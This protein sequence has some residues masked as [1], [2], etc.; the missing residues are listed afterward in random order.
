MQI[1]VL[2][3]NGGKRVT[4]DDS[5]LGWLLAGAILLATSCVWLGFAWGTAKSPIVHAD[6]DYRYAIALMTQQHELNRAV[7]ETV[8]ELEILRARTAAL[9]A[10][11]VRLDLLGKH[12]ATLAGVDAAEFRFEQTASSD[13]KREPQASICH[14]LSRLTLLL[15]DREPK[16]AG[17]EH[18]LTMRQLQEKLTPRGRPVAKGWISSWFGTRKDPLT[19]R[20]A[21]HDGVDF[22]GRYKSPVVAVAAGVV[23]MAKRERGYGNVVQIDHGRGLATRYAHN[24]KNLVKQGDTVSKGDIIA[25]MG[26]S[27]RST[28][29]HVHFEVRRDGKAVDPRPFL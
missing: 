12:V 27:G 9:Q 13:A 6:R 15:D 17:L 8:A 10:R 21:F 19:G 28:G 7:G 4:F 11:T 1:I 16:L 3:D 25:L 18:V 14:N 24:Q 20:R 2:R 23:T 22:A 26:T 5:L 29:A